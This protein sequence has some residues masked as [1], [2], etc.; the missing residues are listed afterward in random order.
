MATNEHTD[1]PGSSSASPPDE[2]QVRRDKRL[3]Q[4]LDRRERLAVIV[5]ERQAHGLPDSREYLLE[6]LTVEQGIEHCWPDVYDRLAYGPWLYADMAR[7]H[8]PQTPL[9]TC[10]ICSALQGQPDAAVEPVTGPFFD[11]AA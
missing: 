9:P 11:E 10:G 2:L 6:L 4:L 1:Q 5:A 3:Q 8:T 7:L